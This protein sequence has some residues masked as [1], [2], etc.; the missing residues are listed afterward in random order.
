MRIGRIAPYC[1]DLQT[2]EYVASDQRTSL[3]LQRRTVRREG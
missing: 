3:N 1:N 2:N